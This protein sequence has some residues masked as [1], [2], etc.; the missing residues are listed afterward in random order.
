MPELSDEALQEFEKQL[1]NNPEFISRLVDYALRKVQVRLWRGVWNGHLPAGREPQDLA[2][3]AIADVLCGKRQ[4]APEKSPDLLHYLYSVVDS[5]INHLVHSQENFRDHL[6]S[7]FANPDAD[8]FYNLED[9]SIKSP[10]EDCQEREMEVFN[11]KL[12]EDLMD[13]LGDDPLL[14]DIIIC[15]MDGLDKRTAIATQL[16]KTPQEITNARKRLKGRIAEFQKTNPD[17]NQ[18]A[19]QR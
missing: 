13:F 14:Q 16:N 8:P 10:D 17:I 19:A 2:S 4:W 12:L 1:Y 18:I 6:V 11:K 5:K 15:T 9:F 3:E 7:S